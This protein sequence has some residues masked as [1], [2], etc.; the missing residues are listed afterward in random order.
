[1][2][3][4]SL[5]S[6]C[7]IGS[8]IVS[9]I[10]HGYAR[11]EASMGD[12]HGVSAGIA[13]SSGKVT[14][15]ILTG[16]K[17]IVINIQDLHCHPE[18]QRNIARILADLDRQ[19]SLT[20]VF[21]EGG[22]GPVDTSWLCGITGDGLR[23]DIVESLVDQGL[24]TGSE[25]FSVLTQRPRLL[26][27]IEDAAVHQEN[28][29]RLGAMLARKPA[30][31]KKLAELRADLGLMKMRHFSRQSRR[32]DGLVTRFNNGTIPPEKYYEQLMRYARAMHDDADARY[33]NIILYCAAARAARRVHQEKAARE[34]Q[35]FTRTLQTRAP[36]IEYLAFLSQMSE[37][38]DWVQRAERCTAMADRYDLALSRFPHVQ[39]FIRWGEL[40]GRVNPVKLVHEQSLLEGQI[41]HALARSNEAADIAFLTGYLPALQDFLLGRISAE[42]CQY[43]LQ[44]HAAF[45]SVWASHARFSSLA[46]L[47]T[48]YEAARAFHQANELRNTLFLQRLPLAAQRDIAGVPAHTRTH[49]TESAGHR[50]EAI[51]VVTGGFHSDGLRSLLHER[52][53][54]FLVIT[55]AVTQDT[56]EASQRFAARAVQQAARISR[57]AIQLALASQAATR[58]KFMFCLSGAQRHLRD[59]PFT[60]DN[61]Q[62]VVD[63]VREVLGNAS[64][65]VTV[66]ETNETAALA[67]AD[68]TAVTLTWNA[69]TG[70]VLT[71]GTFKP[72]PLPAAGAIAAAVDQLVAILKAETISAEALVGLMPM[73]GRAAPL[74]IRVAAYAANH[75]F[76]YGNGYTV[77]L[78]NDEHLRTYVNDRLT[79]IAALLPGVAQDAAVAR[80]QREL[81]IEAGTHTQLMKA[82]LAVD[83]LYDFLSAV[84]AFGRKAVP[85][86]LDT[87]IGW[88]DFRHADIVTV[89][90]CPVCGSREHAPVGTVVINGKALTL[91]QCACGMI[92]YHTRPPVSFYEQLYGPAYFGYDGQG[93]EPHGQTDST[94]NVGIRTHPDIEDIARRGIE[95]WKRFLPAGENADAPLRGRRIVEVGPGNGHLLVESQRQGAEV[96]GVD[97]SEFI[98]QQLQE[99]G[100]PGVVGELQNAGIPRDSVDGLA[101]YDLVEH[102]F[103]LDLFLNTVFAMLKP[104]GFL[105]IRTPDT[106][107]NTPY[108]HLIDHVLH[109]SQNTLSEAL[110]RHGFTV[111]YA[112]PSNPFTG[113]D[114]KMI[115]N[116]IVFAQKPID[117]RAASPAAATETRALT[118]EPVKGGMNP[119]LVLPET[120]P[121]A[122]V[123]EAILSAA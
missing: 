4:R 99:K 111:V 3:L 71:T 118:P 61:I 81:R 70:S 27:G 72:G 42:R 32:F 62:T 115:D 55:P 2:N 113:P 69:L 49:A 78:K 119:A 83:M 107:D 95:L 73:I 84:N 38:A 59:L 56:A 45:Q 41:R 116:M 19:F 88:A 63:T 34:L 35:Q 82:V 85:V 93:F 87:T 29:A 43:V 106:N 120:M 64:C 24:L 98:I 91:A 92:W 57:Q 123:L 94:F 12:A 20:H 67:F 51:V 8:M 14:E 39:N 112:Q 74:F 96:L 122:E 47:S 16:S 10:P 77:E 90:A 40:S 31:E 48:D 54:S 25:Y 80:A 79:T 37:S 1:M 66:D 7:T 46:D 58:D 9:I 121:D 13:P 26:Q 97:I 60:R 110:R 5:I 44:N 89:P 86:L 53:I 104:G 18:V 101:A 108:L 22:Y 33:P 100:V 117:G 11:A 114:G 76:L 102:V 52:G 68:G 17:Q 15:S 36:Y 28:I 65:T 23:T 75:G 21:V 103:D 109:F 30:V 50:V 105:F 6:L